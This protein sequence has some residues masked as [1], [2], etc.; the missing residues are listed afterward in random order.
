MK[1]N[2]D[3]R[4]ESVAPVEA[5]GLTRELG[6]ILDVYDADNHSRWDC[7]ADGVYTRRRPAVGQPRASSQEVFL[8][9]ATAEKGS[10]PAR[11][12]ARRT[13]KE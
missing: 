13:R 3:R 12:R 2:L 8:M 9:M 4:V 10:A 6:A 1:R 7:D 11:K 5:P